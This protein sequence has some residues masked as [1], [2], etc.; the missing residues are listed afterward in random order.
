MA[1]NDKSVRIYLSEEVY[2]QLNKEGKLNSRSLN[3]IISDYIKYIDMK[4]LI[5]FIE[6]DIKIAYDIIINDKTIE[7]NKLVQLIGELRYYKEQV[8]QKL[9]SNGT[10]KK[11]IHVDVS[12]DLAPKEL[13]AILNNF[14]SFD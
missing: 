9:K 7:N 6:H 13:S 14:V 10:I 2:Q 4:T 5:E 3:K 11:H 12:L 8:D 1:S